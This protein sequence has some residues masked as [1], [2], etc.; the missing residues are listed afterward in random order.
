MDDFL[1]YSGY[2]ILLIN[3][4]LYS[5]S[6]FRKEKANGFFVLYLAF[7][8]LMQMSMELLYHLHYNNL[9]LVNAFIIGQMVL[10]GLFYNSLIKIR[11]QK[12]FVKSV[13]LAGIS[14]F[15]VQFLINPNEFLKFNL[16]AITLTSLCCVI[17]GLLHF[18]N[19][20]TE[21]K[22]YY[23]ITIAVIF[24]MLGSTVLYL[25]GNL[26]L[27][28]SLEV[29]Y[30]SWK[31]NAFLFLVYQLVILYEWKVSFSKKSLEN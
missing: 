28:L 10:L 25:I 5:I 16:F 7:A 3:L 20:L 11:S 26:T 21:K 6:F 19:M 8:F 30:F 4:V 17:F 23:Y 27:T 12:I 15:C 31:L 13:L 14:I 22:I 24:F 18:Y 2:L 29:K 9:F 1:I